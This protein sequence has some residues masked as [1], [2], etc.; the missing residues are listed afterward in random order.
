PLHLGY[1]ISYAVF[2]LKKNIGVLAELY[3][4]KHDPATRGQEIDCAVTEAM[5]RALDFL[6]IEYDQLGAV[7]TSSG[8][9]SQYSA[10]G[11]IYATS[12]CKWASIAASTQSIFE[13]FCAALEL[14]YLVTD[15]RFLDN[16]LRVKN[17]RAIDEIVS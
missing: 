11:N 3:R 12:D 10:P 16:P 1:P 17:W 8:N 5:M 2:C 7:R 15:P 9:R 14:Q 4:L 6:A 13:R